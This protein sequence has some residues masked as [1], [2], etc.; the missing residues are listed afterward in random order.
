[1]SEYFA[2]LRVEYRNT[3]LTKSTLHPNPITQSNIW[4]NQAI[5]AGALMPNGVS[6][7]TTD[8]NEVSV[9][10]VLIKD[11][12]DTGFIFFTDYTSKKAQHISTH[13]NVGLLFNWLELDRQI[14]ISGKCERISKEDSEAYFYTR[15]KESQIA[16]YVSQQSQQVSSRAVLDAE[17][18][19]AQKTFTNKKVPMPDWGGYLVVP[20]V[21]EFWQGN[22][23]RLHDTI[24]YQKTDNHWNTE[25][26]YP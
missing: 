25:R 19:V 11:I 12:T 3:P 15:P 18:E 14:K 23:G 9:R 1:M 17:Y 16:A 5:E 2:D 7:A 4:L 26:L 22:A 20:N 6:L 10:T 21:I 13:Q 8:T 24:R